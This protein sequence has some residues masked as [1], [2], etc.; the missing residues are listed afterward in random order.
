MGERID[1]IDF[2]RG[3]ALATILINHIPGNV[4]GNFTPRNYGFSDSAEAFVF[5]SGLSVALAYGRPFQAAAGREASGALARRAAWLY[6]VHLVLTAMA[7]ALYG[8]ASIASGREELL[9]SHGRL[10]PFVDPLRAMVGIVTLG[11][12]IGYF[13]ILPLYVVFLCAAPLLLVLAMRNRWP[14]LFASATLYV[15]ARS[16]GLNLPSWP[17]PGVWY[18]NP[19]AWQFMFAIGV[20]CGLALRQGAISR[21]LGAYRSAQLFTY[22]AAAIVSDAFGFV[23][24]AVEAAGQYLDW[25][26]TDLGTVRILDFLALA[27]FIYCSN[28]TA[29]LRSTPIYAP[30]SLLG[31]HALPVYCFGAILSAVGQILGEILT[32]SALFDI[33]FVG[34]CLKALHSFAAALERRRDATAI[35]EKEQVSQETRKTA[36]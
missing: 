12:Q 34:A 13:N 2:W 22:V 30:I 25:D 27:Y 18:F 10:T 23:P 14:M 4:L 9:E 6:S 32:A 11:H 7:T 29:K 21:N 3:A 19:L 28:I 20:F 16:L 31:R 35:A 17:E 36:G 1:S 15:G 24:G 26:K 8:V 33:L 5:L